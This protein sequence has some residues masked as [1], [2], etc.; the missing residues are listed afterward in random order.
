M[1]TNMEDALAN[2]D[3]WGERDTVHKVQM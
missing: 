1:M 3:G 2:K